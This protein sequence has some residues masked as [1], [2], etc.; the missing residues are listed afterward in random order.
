VLYREGLY[1]D[2]LRYLQRA[3]EHGS[4]PEIYL[5]LGEVEWKMGR[6]EAAISTWEAGLERYPGNPA[7][8]DRLER[9]RR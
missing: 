4:D 2:A 8:Q 5:H 7:L 3:Q 1:E 6:R 9:A